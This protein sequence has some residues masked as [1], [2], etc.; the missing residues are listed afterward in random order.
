MTRDIMGTGKANKADFFFLTKPN[1][2]REHATLDLL[3]PTPNW[4]KF[5][6]QR[7]LSAMGIFFRV[8]TNN[9]QRLTTNDFI[10]LTSG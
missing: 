2:I 5:A 3:Y 1:T 9:R 4:L 7:P 10:R 8:T 6:L